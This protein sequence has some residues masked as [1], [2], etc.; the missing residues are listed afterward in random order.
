[1]HT[2]TNTNTCIRKTKVR[3]LTQ[4]YRIDRKNRRRINVYSIKV[5]RKNRRRIDRR[6]I[7]PKKV[8]EIRVAVL[9]VAV[10]I[11]SRRIELIAVLISSQ[12]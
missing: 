4:C 1:M 3:G 8:A 5:Y 6:R 2:N 11:L 7:D 10:I 9:T 12:Y